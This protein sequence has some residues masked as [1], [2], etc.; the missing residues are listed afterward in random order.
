MPAT[1]RLWTCAAVSLVL[2]AIDA[3]EVLGVSDII[4]RFILIVMVKLEFSA[5]L[6]NWSCAL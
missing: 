5:P 1:I 4:Q 6:G 3:Q 2:A